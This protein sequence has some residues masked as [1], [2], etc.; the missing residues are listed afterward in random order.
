MG[1]MMTK[2]PAERGAVCP[3]LQLPAELGKLCWRVGGPE[4]PE[5]GGRL[6]CGPGPLL[7]V[8]PPWPPQAPALRDTAPSPVSLASS[9]WSE[10][11]YLKFSQEM[12]SGLLQCLCWKWSHHRRLFLFTTLGI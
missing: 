12:G 1:G 10:Q 3:S 8:S 7:L 11:I 9:A 4:E 2:G 5:Q 6:G